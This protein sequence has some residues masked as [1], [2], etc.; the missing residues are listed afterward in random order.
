MSA[1][2]AH[3]HSHHASADHEEI[4]TS[5]RQ[6]LHQDGK[7]L[8]IRPEIVDELAVHACVVLADVIAA[9]EDGGPLDV[10]APGGGG[11]P[12]PGMDWA[13]LLRAGTTLFEVL[14]PIA[15]RELAP[16]DDAAVTRI[17]VLLHQGIT[18]RVVRDP[19]ARPVPPRDLILASRRDERRRMTRELHDQVL[20]G[21]GLA[22]Q[23]LDL[24]RYHVETSPVLARAKVDR[25]IGL[26]RQVM[27]TLQQFS[28]E[29]RRSVEP[30]GLERAL[31]SYLAA[32]VEP[33]VNVVIRT[34][35]DLTSLP[36]DV[37]EEVYLIV[38]EAI[39]NAVRHASPSRLH[40]TVEV[41]GGTVRATVADDGVGFDPGV[42]PA[43]G[44]LAS[45]QERA[46][47]LRGQF[48]WSSVPGVGTRVELRVPLTGGTQ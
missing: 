33:S 25:A 41:N 26:L 40:I 14:L 19:L 37:N 21:M 10:I 35:G 6:A 30:G 31:R 9:V 16:P 20:H 36:A 47:L 24:H 42:S 1:S 44:G 11:W 48:T 4:I 17:S 3:V 46:M 28:V 27:S 34:R 5:V 15:L 45:M 12:R 39:R 29:L 32:H 7:G 22:M 38:R 43:G 18:A 8:A 2:T 23:S 13:Q